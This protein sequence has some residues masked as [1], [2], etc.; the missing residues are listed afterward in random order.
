MNPEPV[1]DGPLPYLRYVPEGKNYPLLLFLHGSGERG[2]DL[3]HVGD[4]GLRD[5]LTRLPEPTLVLAPQCPETMRWTDHL[6]GLETILDA[7]LGNYPVDTTRVYL[8]GLSLGGQGA[9]SLAARAPER[10]AALVPICGRSKP[11]EAERLGA[12]P[13]WA[14][15]GDSD[16]TVPLGE[17]T[18]MVEALHK[19]GNSAKLTVFPQTAHNSW[20]PAY[21]TA[22]LYSWLF[23]QRRHV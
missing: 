3:E 11:E 14:F 15:H 23:A 7:T 13:I 5:I 12:L 6:A 19:A 8:T 9:W 10:F 1:T 17:S 2:S 20:T 22:E 4:H 16:D 21:T 18:R